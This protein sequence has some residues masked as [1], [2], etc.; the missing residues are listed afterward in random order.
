M[1]RIGYKV[2]NIPDGVTVSLN[3]KDNTVTA[4]GPKGEL[5]RNVSPKIKI[6]LDNNQLKFDRSNDKDKAIHGTTRANVNNM[7]DGVKNG[8]KK[9]LELVGVGYRAQKK[10]TKL[11]LSVGYSHPVEMEAPKGVEFE[12]PSNTSIN[13]SGISKQKV[14]QFAAVIRGV[15]PPEPYKGKGIKYVGEHIRRKEGKTGK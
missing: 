14:G 4:K 15:R 9:N 3:E 2:I 8:F 13:I 11:I 7:I 6:T 10:G 1:S 5:T 12:V